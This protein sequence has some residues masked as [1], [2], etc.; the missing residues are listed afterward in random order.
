MLLNGMRRF[1]VCVLFGRDSSYHLSRNCSPLEPRKLYDF[2]GH[3]MDH[4]AKIH[5]LVTRRR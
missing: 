1:D 4:Y 3:C 5:K 2:L